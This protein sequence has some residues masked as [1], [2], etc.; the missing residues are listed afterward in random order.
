V[1]QSTGTTPGSGLKVSP[2][3]N[4]PL[5]VGAQSGGLYSTLKVR[6]SLELVLEVVLTI[7]AFFPDVLQRSDACP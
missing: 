7:P 4:S 6:E 1:G 5:L 3:L 2:R